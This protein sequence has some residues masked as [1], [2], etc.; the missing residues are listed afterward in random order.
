[1][2]HYRRN[3]ARIGLFKKGGRPP[4]HRIRCMHAIQALLAEGQPITVGQVH[5]GAG[6][7]KPAQT[8]NVMSYFL[9]AGLTAAPLVGAPHIKQFEVTCANT[10]TATIRELTEIEKLL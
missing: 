7:G 10:W 4:I 8:Y 3:P 1:M 6:V 2:K 9:T 5:K